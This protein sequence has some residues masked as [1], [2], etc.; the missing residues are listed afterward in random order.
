MLKLLLCVLLQ[1]NGHLVLL[2]VPPSPH[3]FAAGSLLFKRC[4]HPPPQRMLSIMPFHSHG[5]SIQFCSA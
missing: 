1:T 3:S 4:D 5:A 2:G